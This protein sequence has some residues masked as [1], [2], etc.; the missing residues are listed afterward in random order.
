MVDFQVREQLDFPEIVFR[1]IDRVG[2]IVCTSP[3]NYSQLGQAVDFLTVVTAPLRKPKKVETP[4]HR[5]T[6]PE[7]YAKAMQLVAEVMEALQEKGLL[8]RVT[9]SGRVRLK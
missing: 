9:A 1:A 4:N 6:G 3:I 8:Y 5:L 7:Y 2:L